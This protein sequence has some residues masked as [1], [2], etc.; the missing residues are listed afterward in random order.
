MSEHKYIL[1]PYKGMNTRYDC[2]SCG[3]RKTFSRYLDT[4]TGEHLHPSVGR[5]N[6]EIN[7][8]YHYTPKQYFQDNKPLFD[9]KE[10]KQ[11]K[12]KQARTPQPK[13]PVSF[14]PFEVFE[15]SLQ[16]HTE[17]NFVKFLYGLFGA[18]I[19]NRLIEKYFIGTSKHWNGANV[20]W[21][22]AEDGIRTGKIMLYNPDTGKRVKDKINWVHS[23][24]KIEGFNLK[25]CFFGQHLLKGNTKPV[26]IVESEK[27]AVI[28]SVYLPQFIW[29][30]VGSLTNLNAEKCSILKG[31]SV[32]LFP[33]LNGFEKWRTKA[34]EISRVFPSIRFTVSD[35]LERKASE[36]ERQQ[37]LDLADYLIRFDY[38]DFQLQEQPEHQQSAPEQPQQAVIETVQELQPVKETHFSQTEAPKPES[39]EQDITELEH[40]FETATLPA[41][42]V[43]LNPYS[44]ITNVA[45]F[46]HSHFATVKANN[47]K[48]TFLPY[49]N[50]LQELKQYLTLNSN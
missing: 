10:P 6:R 26:A 16:Q 23:V 12:P 37:G 36:T 44:T 40:Y 41:V 4:E 17:N 49:L 47:G 46:I 33:D 5:C 34:K 3:K 13:P 30:A 32:T 48:R 50:R 7:C 29:V 31:R 27:T 19:T 38:R 45:L 18:V 9:T 15:K 39:W 43:K 24:L 42:P 25:Q 11:Y 14:I 2:P 1:E 8:G 20:F 22:I 21:Q 28:A 35:L